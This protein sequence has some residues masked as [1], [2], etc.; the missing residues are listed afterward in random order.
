[1]RVCVL[2]AEKDAAELG[3]ACVYPASLFAVGECFILKDLLT[4]VILLVMRARISVFKF[5][6]I[7]G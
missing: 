1:M 7:C 2:C 6:F 3:R 5:L 4:K